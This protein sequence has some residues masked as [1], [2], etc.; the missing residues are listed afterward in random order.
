MKSELLDHIGIQT[1]RKQLKSSAN[2]MRITRCLCFVTM[3]LSYFVF[4]ELFSVATMGIKY[5]I[6]RT[7]YS[8]QNYFAAGFWTLCIYVLE[9]NDVEIEIVGDQLEAENALFISNH[10]SL[11][12]YIIYP[13]LV[14]KSIRKPSE[15]GSARKHEKNNEPE[16][17]FAQDLSSILLP[18]VSF[19]TWYSI[20]TIPS[21]R[22]FKNVFQADENWE[23]NN[24]TLAFVFKD[25]LESEA[26]EW[27]VTF[28]EVNIFTKKDAKLQ[29][30]LSEKFYLPNLKNLLYPRYSSFA[31]VVSGLHKT[32][33]TRLYDTSIMYYR[34]APGEPVSFEAPNL[35]E[36]FG[37]YSGKITIKIH[38]HAKMM[39]RIPLK[40]NK[41]EKWLEGKWI[42]KDRLITKLKDEVI[43][44]GPQQI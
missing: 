37:L 34:Q 24:E 19:F 16:K 30:G 35:L 2:Y 26:I 18:K 17:L 21:L 7:R 20:W 14:L 29:Q 3:L 12:D 6:P 39:S 33:F 42:K 38:I 44:D 9:L 27:L 15:L 41:L 36:V 43:R 28:P 1:L 10:A 31:N 23:L 13:Y 4:Y 25:L 5:L 22:V 32:Q 8:Y 11:V 40:R